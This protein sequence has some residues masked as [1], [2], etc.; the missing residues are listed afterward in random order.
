MNMNEE[1]YVK[2]CVMMISHLKE[3]LKIIGETTLDMKLMIITLRGMHPIWETFITTIS[4][5]NRFLS[6][7][8]LIG[9]ATQEESRMIFRGRIHGSNE[10]EPSTHVAQGKKQNSKK[11]NGKLYKYRIPHQYDQDS[12]VSRSQ[13]MLSATIVTERVT[14]LDIVLKSEIIRE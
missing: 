6:F 2:S 8:K 12:K 1:E 13:D 9:N 14:I 11:G 3:K 10:G 7:D 5:N 4:K